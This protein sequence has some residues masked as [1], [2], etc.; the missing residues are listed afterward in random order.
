MCGLALIGLRTVQPKESFF[1][2]ED[3]TYIKLYRKSKQNPLMRDQL[4]WMVFSW[5]MLSVDYQTGKMLC[6]RFWGA[7]WF[8]LNPSTFYSVLK[9]LDKKYNVIKLNSNNK[10]TEIC[11]INWAKYQ[12]DNLLQQQSN[13][14][15]TTNQQQ[16][17]TN[18]EVKNIRKKE[19]TPYNPPLD[20]L[21]EI[22]ERYGVP[23]AF[24]KFQLETLQNYIAS[25]GKIYKDPTAALRNF[26]L[27]D[28]KKITERRQS[29][30]IS[31]TKIS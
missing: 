1:M 15:V 25:S 17:N 13:N 3:L 19:D 27:R 2:S 26:V 16:S 12:Q 11:V 5:I 24:V 10:N 18:Q 6:G 20:V 4:A 22:A 21:E 30:G 28:A 9:R 23:L 14:K 31:Y 7:E 8:S 29:N